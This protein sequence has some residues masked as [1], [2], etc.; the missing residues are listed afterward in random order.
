[1]SSDSLEILKNFMLQGYSTVGQ[2]LSMDTTEEKRLRE[3]FFR[4]EK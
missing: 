1:M 4:V 3:D 2:D